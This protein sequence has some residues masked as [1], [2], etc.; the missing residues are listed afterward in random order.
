MTVTKVKYT[1]PTPQ[2]FFACPNFIL[3]NIYRRNTFI[4]HVSF[5]VLYLYFFDIFT[6]LFSTKTT[7]I[8]SED[9]FNGGVTDHYSWSQTISDVDV[10]II[11]PHIIKKSKDLSI[12]IR[13]DSIS[14]KLK[15]DPPPGNFD[16]NIL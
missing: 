1:A 3:C 7:N 6:I 8:T 4:V 12:E 5:F 9:S 15:N 11:V 16:S 13:T 10:K 14:V 2:P